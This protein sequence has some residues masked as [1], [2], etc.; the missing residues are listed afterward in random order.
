MAIISK[1]IDVSDIIRIMGFP[2]NKTKKNN[3]IIRNG[4]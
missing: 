4:I 2:M 3:I 1:S